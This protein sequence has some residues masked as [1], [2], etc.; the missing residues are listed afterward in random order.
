MV[1]IPII[2]GDNVDNTADY[3]DALP[4]NLTAVSKNI[5]GASGYLLSHPGLT[6]FGEGV[7]VDRGGYWNERQNIHFRVS[8][9][10]LVGLNENG[11]ITQFGS[12]SGI[13]RA[14]LVHSFNSQAVVSD[15]RMWLYDGT[16][17]E[18]TDPDLGN[19]IDVTWIDGY[20][21]LTD[22]EFLYH[23][24]INDETSIDPLK[25]A[26]SEFSPDP[27]LA[28]DK[29][30]D[31]QVIVFNRYSI[32]YFVNRATDN[33]AFQRIQGKAVK[34]GCVGTHCETELEGRFYIIGGG[35]EEAVSVHVVAAG[36]YRSIATREVDK[37]LAEYD[38]SELALS[39]LETR[40]EDRDK[41]LVCH[42]P[43]HTL[44][45]NATIAE[46]LG[47]ENAWTIIKTSVVTD[48]AWRGINGVYD[49]RISKWV[50]GDRF[51]SNIGILDKSLASQYGEQVESIFYSPLFNMES[52]SIDELEVQTVPG[53]QVDPNDVKCAIS[54]T[55]QGFTYGKE[56]WDLYGVQTV[57]DTRFIQR[58]LGYVREYVGI[59]Y[60]AVSTARLNFLFIRL[61]YG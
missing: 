36:A 1:D 46:K 8:G 42:L 38:E 39:V 53:H 50:Y 48:G 52:A 13:N 26:T 11:S 12:V 57:Y 10:Q 58:R 59:K 34:C 27:T 29:T 28:V 20:Y 19:P 54:L 33:F 18:I 5:L 17:N 4:V 56:W 16:L 35:R 55:Y 41:Y 40:V 45:Y 15:G 2:K 60:R 25:F 37:I 61:K 30:S 7:G 22:G 43:N 9:T 14:S 21:F 24:D 47:K 44:L 3:R 6:Y 31:N 49:P 32:E 23:T 51:N